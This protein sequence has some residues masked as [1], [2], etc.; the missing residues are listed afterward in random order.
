MVAE[1][2][3]RDCTRIRHFL[4]FLRILLRGISRVKVIGKRSFL[5]FV[6]RACYAPQQPGYDT[7]HSPGMPALSCENFSS[8][9]AA[10]QAA[11]RPH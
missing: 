6:P 4:R 2:S 11:A 9:L 7:L 8:P 1:I 3:A 10:V 5:K